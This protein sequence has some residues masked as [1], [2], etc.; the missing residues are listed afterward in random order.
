VIRPGGRLCLL[1]P[2]AALLRRVMDAAM[3]RV[4]FPPPLRAR[5]V[6]YLEERE[7]YHAWL[8]RWPGLPDEIRRAGFGPPRVRRLLLGAA[9][10][11][12]RP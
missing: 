4:P 12:P 8:R 6:T 2:R 1:E 10:E 3:D 9:L 5:Q 11:C 7:T